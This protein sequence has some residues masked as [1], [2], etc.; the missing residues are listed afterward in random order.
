MATGTLVMGRV[1]YQYPYVLQQSPNCDSAHVYP[2]SLPQVPSGETL[3]ALVLAAVA[4]EV[5]VGTTV[6]VDIVV[7]SQSPKSLSQYVIQ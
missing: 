3:L 1:T 6:D 2:A 7:A 4:L 5:E